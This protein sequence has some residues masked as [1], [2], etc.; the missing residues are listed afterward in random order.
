MLRSLGMEIVSIDV[1]RP[2]DACSRVF[3]TPSELMHWVTGLGGA[4][5]VASRADG[6]PRGVKFELA[7]GLS[8]TLRLRRR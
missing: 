4:T 6:L 8:Y 1:Q 2:T 3:T 5:L 7:A